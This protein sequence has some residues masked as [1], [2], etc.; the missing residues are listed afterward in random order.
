MLDV[1]DG[2][3]SLS[4]LSIGE[5]RRARCQVVTGDE[6]LATASGKRTE[7]AAIYSSVPSSRVI[8]FIF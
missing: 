4:F 3:N 6:A 2:R 7:L 8:H 1:V 5:S